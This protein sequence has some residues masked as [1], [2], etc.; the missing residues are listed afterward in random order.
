[1]FDALEKNFK[2]TQQENLINELSDKSKKSYLVLNE[3]IV[4]TE[5]LMKN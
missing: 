2:G 5:N 1:M 4:I 3:S